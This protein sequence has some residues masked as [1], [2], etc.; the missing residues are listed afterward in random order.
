MCVTGRGLLGEGSRLRRMRDLECPLDPTWGGG[1]EISEM[2]V[3]VWELLSW[4]QGVCAHACVSFERK[5][6]RRGGSSR[7]KVSWIVRARLS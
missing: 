7:N 2:P 1:S 5:S 6:P 3:I 4:G